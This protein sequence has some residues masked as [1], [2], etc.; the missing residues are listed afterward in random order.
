MSAKFYSKSKDGHITYTYDDQFIYAED[1]EGIRRLDIFDGHYYK[2]RIF[3]GVPILE[4]DGLRMQL[5]RDFETPLDYSI[6]VVSG[7]KISNSESTILDTCMGLGYTAISASKSKLVKKVITCEISEAVRLLAK[8]SP[9]S[10]ELFEKNGKIEVLAGSAFDL[11]KEFSDSSFSYIIHD[12]PRFSH[13]PELY[14]SE[15][16]SE[17]FRVSKKGAKLF[18]YVGS[19]GIAKGIK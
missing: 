11:I 18:H 5:V 17:L 8:W 1:K 6:E 16:Y 12:P 10:G 4:I 3:K 13:A 19:V 2:L 7:L 15:F 9:S 14:S